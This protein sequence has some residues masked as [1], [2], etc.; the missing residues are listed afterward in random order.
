MEDMNSIHSSSGME[1]IYKY[2][3]EIY[4]IIHESKE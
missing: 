2:I 4:I 1:Q 3:A